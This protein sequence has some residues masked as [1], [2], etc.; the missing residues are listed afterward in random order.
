MELS[1]NRRG[2]QMEQ[3][4]QPSTAI[5]ED[6]EIDTGLAAFAAE[7]ADASEATLQPPLT[8]TL[9]SAAQRDP[10]LT[11]ADVRTGADIDV[12]IP[13]Q[14]QTQPD[15]DLDLQGSVLTAVSPGPTTAGIKALAEAEE[16]AQPQRGFE[17]NQ[18]A[19]AQATRLAQDHGTFIDL[20]NG[21][22]IVRTAEGGVKLQPAPA[23][24]PVDTEQSLSPRAV[25]KRDLELQAGRNANQRHQHME[26]NRPVPVKTKN[27]IAA[28]GTSSPVFR[29][30]E[31]KEY[32][33][34]KAAAVSKDAG[35][36]AVFPPQESTALELGAAARAAGPTNY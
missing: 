23:P 10:L 14:P 4:Q 32:R 11:T 27:E 9:Q 17:V 25:T 34:L 33:D 1:A 7:P 35:S 20:G 18:P 6:D 3:N 30:G 19:Q 21:D 26:R 5:P 15:P 2:I 8:S 12:V 22:K 31:F 36:K 24:A 16:A 13:S 29:P 28:E